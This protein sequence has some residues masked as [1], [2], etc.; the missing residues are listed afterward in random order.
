MPGEGDVVARKGRIDGVDEV[1]EVLRRAGLG[2]VV[3]SVRAGAG[4]RNRVW[5]VSTSGG[6]DV[7]VRFLADDR[8]LLMEQR[9][10]GVAAAH[11]LPV[12]E[13]LWA[14]ATPTPV[15][16]QRR[17]PGRMLSEVAAP[18]DV[19]LDSLADVLRAVHSLPTAGGF[20]NLDADLRGEAGDLATW[21]IDDVRAE[22]EALP[23]PA[24]SELHAA[25]AELEWARPL[26]DRQAPGLVH[27]DV[28]PTNLLIGDDG[29][30]T[31]LL[32]WEAAK[33]GPPAFDFGWWDWFSRARGTPW[34]TERL[35][36]RYGDV[37]DDTDELRR[38]VVL[39]VETRIQCSRLRP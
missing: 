32:D 29:L 11:G 2:A 1:A 4:E 20:G 30:V 24:P 10:L 23:S 37:P 39:R 19:S 34:P 21:F 25:V 18:T 35:L 8:R 13:V 3:S 33:S 27:G 14:E 26:L 36:E 28:Q 22:V 17:L 12:A 15:V 16:V 5:L 9:L 31:G 7:V 6:P 38:L